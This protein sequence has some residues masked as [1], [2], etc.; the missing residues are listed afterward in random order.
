MT[1]RNNQLLLKRSNVIN[2]VPPL[3]GLTLGEIALNTAD[4][5]LYTIYTLGGAPV[6]V[7]DI[8]WDKFPT[9]GGT[10]NGD[11]TINGA[12]S[13]NSIELSAITSNIDNSIIK[14]S[15]TTTNSIDLIGDSSNPTSAQIL[16]DAD[17]TAITL[18]TQYFDFKLPN[19]GS[20]SYNLT[21]SG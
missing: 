4:A 5:K 3:S 21:K 16:I 15:T 13:V 1:T 2:K 14:L 11:V 7:R 6:G 12:L 8:G 20:F 19:T 18:E 17:N 9:S 10:I